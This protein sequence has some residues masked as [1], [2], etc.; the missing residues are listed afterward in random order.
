MRKITNMGVKWKRRKIH[1]DRSGTADTPTVVS[2]D[3]RT[4]MSQQIAA[5]ASKLNVEAPVTEVITDRTTDDVSRVSGSGAS[6]FGAN[7]HKTK[8]KN[9]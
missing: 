6:M 8:K 4:Q 1:E 2:D 5:I 7:A 9:E 3:A